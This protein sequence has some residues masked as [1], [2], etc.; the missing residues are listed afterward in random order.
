MRRRDDPGGVRFV[1]FSCERRL[2]LLSNPRIAAVFIE[3]LA[4]ARER[5]GFKL[6]AYV[7]M[8]E[9]VT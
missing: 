9:H 8:P 2:P 7:V 6:F 4:P 1:T 3:A 5:F